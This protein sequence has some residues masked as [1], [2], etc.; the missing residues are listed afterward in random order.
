M[1]TNQQASSCVCG[2]SILQD[3][4]FAPT[5]PDPLALLATSPPSLHASRFVLRLARMA[6]PRKGAARKK[7]TTF[8]TAVCLLPLADASHFCA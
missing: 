5:C 7:D 8:G 1:F 6:K 4:H 2:I 3:V